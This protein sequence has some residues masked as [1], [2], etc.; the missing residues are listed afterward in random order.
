[1]TDGGPLGSTTVI[2]YYLYQHGFQFFN[3]G[4]ASAVACVLFVVLLSLTLIQFKVLGPRVH[5]Q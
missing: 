1:M 3:L 4:Y 5:Y 2:A